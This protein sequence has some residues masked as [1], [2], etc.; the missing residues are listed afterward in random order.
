MEP[1]RA[2]VEGAV[3]AE[4]WTKTGMAKMWKLDSFLRESQR[5]NGIRTRTSL[6]MSPFL[7]Y[8]SL[9]LLILTVSIVRKAMKDMTL[10]DGT[11]IPRGT[12]VSVAARP[13]HHDQALYSDAATFDPFRFARMRTTDGGG[14]KHQ[15]V[16]TSAEYLPFGHGRHAW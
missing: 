16:H 2:E 1:L 12:L 7:Q 4:G 15:M 11:F 10:S 6:P 9:M 5:F 13:T 14:T 8:H 3:A